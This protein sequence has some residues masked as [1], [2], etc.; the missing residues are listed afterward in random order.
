MSSAPYS[1]RTYLSSMN[2]PSVDD[3]DPLLGKSNFH[4]WRA[5]VQPI[6]LTNNYSSNLFLGDWT[7]PNA[8]KLNLATPNK[9][10][11]RD[12]LDQ[13]R[14]EWHIANTGTCRFIRSTLAMN[15]TP[16][17]R[18]HNTAKALFFNLIWL[19]G[20]EAGID[21]QGGP[22]VPQ[23]TTPNS[24]TTST[25]DGN[26]KTKSGALHKN[27]AS[28]L[29]AMNQG[30]EAD[31]VRGYLDH[32]SLTLLVPTTTTTS[33]AL[34]PTSTSTTSSSNLN[35][36][37]TS[38]VRVE[39]VKSH[40]SDS[41]VVAS[42]PAPTPLT[43][44]HIYERSRLSPSPSLTTIHEEPHPGRRVSYG[45][46]AEHSGDEG[47]L[48]GNRSPSI[49]PLTLSDTSS[50][51]DYVE[52]LYPFD[53]LAGGA[54]PR[55]SRGPG[56]YRTKTIGNVTRNENSASGSASGSGIM[57]IFGTAGKDKGNGDTKKRGRDRFPF[58]FPLRRL[59]KE[60]QRF[61]GQYS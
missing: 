46:S 28:L 26:N 31:G 39:G 47:E 2:F 32:E 43:R 38:L 59:T 9:E 53:E 58:S 21:M 25:V 18:Q 24:Y 36:S 34:I 42:A 60:R 55:G 37:S 48:T 4:S 30:P 17:V 41:Q 16:F 56:Q 45:H 6:L 61:Q 13:A 19:Y 40:V 10:D 7:E 5:V 29:A 8:A 27:R 50:I 33:T 35:P 23:T 14:R 49:S 54:T 12:Q 44:I 1:S 57:A 15:V 52:D 11:A 3:I 51:V 22:A 20:D